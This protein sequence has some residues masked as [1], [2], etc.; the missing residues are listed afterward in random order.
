MYD[1]FGECDRY[2]IVAMPWPHPGRGQAIAPTM[3]TYRHGRLVH[4]RGDPRGRPAA[5]AFPSRLVQFYCH[6][7]TDLYIAPIADVSA[8]CSFS[9]IQI[10]LLIDIMLPK[11]SH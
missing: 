11:V 9:N 3:P 10:T 4:S 7:P 2:S 5:V 1:F 8:L 6:A